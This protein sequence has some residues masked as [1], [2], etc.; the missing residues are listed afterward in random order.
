MPATNAAPAERQ[1][2]IRH[3][4][5]EEVLYTGGGESLRDVVV[6][7]VKGGANLRG[8]DL[9]GANLRGADL[10]GA[11][12]RGAD[13]GGADLGGANLRGADLYGANLRGADLRGAD[14]YGANLYGA[15]LRGANLGGK[16]LVGP[17]PLLQIG[18]IGSRYDYLIAY[19]TD[20]G[21]MVRAG[22]FFDTLDAFRA[23]VETTHGSSNHGRE[24]TAAI[25]TIEAH[26]EIWTPAAEPAQEAA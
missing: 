25:A 10:Y 24:Y 4:Y 23:A 18:P 17:R 15:N 8:A 26:A 20:A 22:C 3:R 12:L 11:N 14:L 9:G 7:A 5:T 2:E 16:K 19:L 6:A 1:F 13:L 21:V